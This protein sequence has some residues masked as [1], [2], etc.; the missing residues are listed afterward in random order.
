MS[1]YK[2]RWMIVAGGI[3]VAGVAGSADE[4]WPR[5]RGPSDNAVVEAALP[6]E[7][8]D[9]A[10]LAWKAPLPGRG[11]STPVVWDNVIVLTAP[12]DGRDAALAFDTNGREVWRVTFSEERPGRHRSASGCNSSPVTDGRFVWVYFKSGTLAALTLDGTLVW[13]TSIPE[14]FGPDEL[15]WDIGTSPVLTEKHV[16]VNVMNGPNSHLAAFD[17]QTGALAWSVPRNYPCSFEADQGYTTP[18]VMPFAGRESLLVWNAEH[19][20]LHDAANGATL[21]DCGGLNPE[22]QR[23]WPPVASPVLLGDIAVVPYGRGKL[24]HGLRLAG[25]GDVTDTARM[26]TR[27][28]TGSYVPTPLAYKGKVILLRDRDEVDCIDPETGRTEWTGFFEK[29]RT[30]FYASPVIAGGRLYAVR[31]DGVVFVARLDGGFEVIA[32]NVMNEKIWATPVPLGSRMLLRG[33]ST[34]FCVGTK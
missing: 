15:V 32:R 28:D 18:I 29:S 1:L 2:L 16:V 4:N 12:V 5:W 23:N 6:V 21:W 7:W 20:T 26:W 11:C 34:L 22:A 3:V 8:S 9:T 24:L 10:N 19:V 14:R 30:A 17:R 13:Q 33:E 31:E 27:D 25:R